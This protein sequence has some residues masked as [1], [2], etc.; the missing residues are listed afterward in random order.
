MESMQHQ[1]RTGDLVLAQGEY[2]LLQDGTNGNV[3]VIVGP[4]KQSVAETDFL[5]VYDHNNRCFIRT[6][7]NEAI[8][9]DIAGKEGEYIVLHNPAVE[10]EDSVAIHPKRGA[11]DAVKLDHGRKVV[12]PGPANFALYPGQYAEVIEGHQLRSNQYLVV[13][14]YNEEAAKK[15]WETAVVKSADPTSSDEED[16]K[17]NTKVA[18]V[19]KLTIGQMINIKGTEVSFYIPPTGI[20]VVPDVEGNL[21]REAVTLQRL[22]Y[23]ILLAEDGEKRYVRGPAV[24]I[25][26]PTEQLVLQNKSPKYK[27]IELNEG[28]GLYVKVIAD[29]KEGG[30]DYKTGD[31]LFLTGNEM[32]IY[33]PRPEH[34]LIRYGEDLIHYAI[35]IPKGEARYTLNKTTGVVGLVKGPAMY[36]PDPRKEVVVRRILD[37]K[38]CNL[39]YPGNQAVL[40][41]NKKYMRDYE[42]EDDENT[43]TFNDRVMS[44]TLEKSAR[45]IYGSSLMNMDRFASDKVTRNRNFTPPRTI[46]LNTK[47]E[48]AVAVNVW[49]GYAVQVVDKA[50]KRRVVT[51][52]A[53]V[54][55]EYDESLE[56]VK[57]SRGV[58]KSTAKLLETVY[59]RVNNNKISDYIQAETADAVEIG[60]KLSYNVN[61]EGD[62]SKWYDV[63]NYVKFLTDHMRSVIRNAVKKKGIEDVTAN[64]ID[65]IRDIVIGEQD[66]DGKRTGKLFTENGMRIVDVDVLEFKINDGEIAYQLIDSQHKTVREAIKIKSEKN[67]LKTTTELETVVRKIDQLRAETA[68]AKSELESDRIKREAVLQQLNLE[69]QLKDQEALDGLS[70]AKLAR[71]KNSADF[72]LELSK[73]QLEAEVGAYKERWKSITPELVN[74]I[75]SL[76]NK[77]LATAIATNLPKSEG[78]LGMLL[79]V[80]GMDSLKQLLKGTAAE[81]GLDSLISRDIDVD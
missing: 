22:T 76:G 17:E 45:D 32:K 65:I 41:A 34:A 23:A 8:Q 55:L 1:G 47:F 37:T 2:A 66:K 50:G 64:A 60:F 3:Q 16:K 9:R 51:G 14:V 18:Q 12:I 27:A 15:N 80:N 43:A 5:V 59:L 72:E 71:R 78:A 24:V 49:T 46:T 79:G 73:R 81:K 70:A 57:F 36:L 30:K 7:K 58:P 28:M 4:N 54:I 26:E 63:E 67:Q 29:Y 35:A 33:Y 11:S 20:E 39:W 44:T 10:G 68:K 75:T 31:E 40:D 42:I 77:E 74:A 52:P 25:P 48:G 61:F 69:N 62:S 19:Q 21:I 53:T 56:V 6:T 38:T 13:R